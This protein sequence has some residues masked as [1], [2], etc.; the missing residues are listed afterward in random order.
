MRAVRFHSYGDA[1][2]LS[3]D[4]VA[5]PTPGPTDV[6]VAVRAVGVN[7][8]DVDMRNGTSRL[9]LELP[10]TLGLEFGGEIV[11]VGSQVTGWSIG[12]R[13][14]AL[15]QMACHECNWCLRGLQ[16]HCRSMT[17]FGVHRPGGYAELVL[18]PA[19]ALVRLPDAMSFVDAAVTQT[20]FGT[21]W[22]CL[23]G[24]SRVRPGDW[25]LLSGAGSGVG[26]AAIRIARMLGARIITTAGSAEKLAK[27]RDIGADVVID[28]TKDDV[29]KAV[30]DATGGEG[31]QV[32]LEHIGGSN[33]DACL[34]SLATDGRMVVCGGHAG[35]TVPL[36]LIEL[37]R[38]EWSV[39]GAARATEPELHEIVRLVGSGLLETVVD[40][41]FSLD[42]A[43]SAHR[44]ME[45]RLQFGKLVL[46]P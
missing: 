20:S 45:D 32:A 23:T 3:V 37:F 24:R 8:V 34:R 33:F 21:A 16:Q 38:H 12:D 25:V 18:V 36:D 13:V 9:P 22:H 42:D 17:L 15:H 6:V 1:D 10:H 39:V 46:T 2:V 14:T 44:R 4:D 43:A 7:H 28:Y 41:T 5:D 29:P 11:E 19:K 30:M 35:E 40:S 31:V 27:A 26:S